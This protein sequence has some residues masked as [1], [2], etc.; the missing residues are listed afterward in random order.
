MRNYDELISAMN[1][2]ISGKGIQLHIYFFE[3]QIIFITSL[4]PNPVEIC[5]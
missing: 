3:D 2:L 1:R 5:G 4:C